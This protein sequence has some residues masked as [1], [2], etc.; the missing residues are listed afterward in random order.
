LPGTLELS[1]VCAEALK[2]GENSCLLQSHGAVC[3]GASMQ[4]AFK[5]AKV[6]EVTAEI[7]YKIRATGGRPIE[8]S[9]ENIDAMYNFAKY[10]YGQG[11]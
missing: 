4:A 3:V 11:K 6:L 10:H 1:K 5:V 8:L 9:K 7:Y 2:S